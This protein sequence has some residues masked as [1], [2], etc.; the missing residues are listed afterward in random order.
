MF[1]GTAINSETDK[2]SKSNIAS[3]PAVDDGTSQETNEEE[4]DNSN[5][6]SEELPDNLKSLM[7]GPLMNLDDGWTHE[8][9]E[10]AAK[11]ENLTMEVT[12][13]TRIHELR[14]KLQVVGADYDSALKTMDEILELPLTELT[15]KKHPE[16]V[17]TFQKVMTFTGNSKGWKI[18]DPDIH[19]YINKANNIRRKA[20]M[21][22]NKFKSLFTIPEGETFQ[23]VFKKEVEGFL[24]K[25]KNLSCDQIYSM[26]SEEFLN[27]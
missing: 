21:V 2:K 6:N 14:K 17:E 7:V 8:H 25:T 15:L 20:T 10:N 24:I 12:L 5:D 22:Y 4:D 26:T 23:S 27:F 13:L 1:L 19:E 11:I 3:Q 16:V 18:D 9:P